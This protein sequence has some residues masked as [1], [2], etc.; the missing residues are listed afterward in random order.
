[1]SPNLPVRNSVRLF[2][3]S[4][5]LC[6][7]LCAVLFFSPETRA[8]VKFNGVPYLGLKNLANN[9]G[10]KHGW[11]NR[12]KSI[13]LTSQW[14]RL[15][16]EVHKREI[17]I[18]GIRVFLGYP[19]ALKG[20]DL[21]IS[22]MDYDNNILPILTPQKNTKVP[23]LFHIVIDPGHGGKDPGAENKILKI[24]EK[25]ITFDVAIRL[26]KILESN[27]YRITLTRKSD[28]FI[29]LGNRTKIANKLKADLFISVHINSHS[30][31][32][33]RGLETFVLTPCN[34]PSSS[35][36]TLLSTDH[37]LYPG[38]RYDDWNTLAGYYVQRELIRELPSPD[39]GLKRAR[40]KVL[41]H[42]DCP[43]IYVEGGFISH[44]IESRNLGAASYRQQIA[45]AVADGVIRYQ[46]TINRLRE[47]A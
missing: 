2:N 32:K 16:F 3:S 14:S 42:L 30:S 41:R 47:K 11:V 22:N 34:Q 18:N 12:G 6:A 15:E 20:Q 36:K 4:L 35:R 13:V 33:V 5:A 44:A 10:M 23:K 37:T 17:K 19:V 38:N 45:K 43:G 46:K 26:K 31:N 9:L 8:N 39:R 1:M 24:N 25:T 27:G 28:N 7:F 29:D 40:F 21:Y